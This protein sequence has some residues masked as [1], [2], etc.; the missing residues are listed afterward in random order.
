VLTIP[1]KMKM[2]TTRSF[3][4][5]DQNSSSAN[6]RREGEVDQQPSATAEPLTTGSIGRQPYPRVPKM[7]MKMMRNQKL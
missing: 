7:L 4:Q 1:M 3:K 2:T 5:L 6:L